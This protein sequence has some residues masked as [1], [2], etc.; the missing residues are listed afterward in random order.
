MMKNKSNFN[1]ALW[2]GISSVS[3]MLVSIVSA[4]ILSRFFD[5]TEYGT[6]K[7]IIFVYTTL[8]TIFQAG[9]PSV[10][11][12]FL[13]KYPRE[14]GKY[15]VNKINRVLFVLGFM[16]SATIFLS[17]NLIADFLNN[18]ELARGLKLFSPFPL[19]T[20]PTLGLEGIY[21][22]NKNT[23]FVAIYNT[24]T[25][26]LMLLCIVLPVVFIKNSYETAVM[27][28]GAAS[29]FAF[30]IALFYKTRPYKDIEHA[31]E[32]PQLMKKVL[33]YSLPIMGT[34]CV[35]LFYNSINQ[36][37]ISRFF[38]VESF[39][40]FS[41][42]FMPL[43]FIAIIINPIRIML[44][45]MI[46]KAH[47]NG[48]FDDTWRFYNTSVKEITLLIVPM[49]A[50]CFAFAKPIMV[51]LYGEQYA[52][53]YIFFMIALTF[54]YFEIIPMQVI[55]SGLGRTKQL[56][57]FDL[58]FTLLLL[59]INILLVK[60]NISSPVVVA[61]VFSIIQILLRYITPF[62]YLVAK[63][64]L[65]PISKDLFKSILFITLHAVVV[66]FVT[67]EISRLYDGISVFFMLMIS[68]IAFYALLVGTGYLLKIN[69]LKSF[70]RL[71]PHG[72]K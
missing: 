64:K 69:Y 10:F 45:P 34:S 59:G 12:Y 47:A 67:F 19:F 32:I 16:L 44:V 24:V 55:L 18:P 17:S 40:E 61:V 71:I 14:A 57:I 48:N 30:I 11:S 39:A 22:V 52:S 31:E 33:A 25:R 42:G 6:Y 23:R 26:L 56:F 66:A 54:N 28:W 65:H 38:G 13:P 15:I 2:L 1:Q 20:L 58:I 35:M 43:P 27:G 8:L 50:F 72:R 21:V 4:A 62:V 7:Q 5:K 60:L 36:L 29:F 49:V 46:S 37:V 9:L 68:G 70:K 53:S 3:T 41:N 51:F 63:E